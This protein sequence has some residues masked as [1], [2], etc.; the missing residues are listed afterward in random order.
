MKTTSKYK[1]NNKAVLAP[2]AMSIKYTTQS[3][4]ADRSESGIYDYDKIQDGIDM[5][6]TFRPKSWN[7]LSYICG[8][9]STGDYIEFTYQD[10]KT[11]EYTTGTFYR[12]EMN[13]DILNDTE[14]NK[15]STFQVTVHIVSKNGDKR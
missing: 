9:L 1:I 14:D 3:K 2:T 7:E 5:N 12:G 10:P 8:L 4:T 11:A 6:L 13:I 15:F